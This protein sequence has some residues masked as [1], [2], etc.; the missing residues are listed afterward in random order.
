MVKF[1]LDI[2]RELASLPPGSRIVFRRGFADIVDAVAFKVF[3]QS[4]SPA[5]LERII[6]NPG[7]NDF[8]GD[9]MDLKN[10]T[11]KNKT[12]DTLINTKTKQ[13]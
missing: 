8:R 1:S 6:R 10:R 3:L 4:L 5:S 12:E 13:L 2:R 7:M 9:F 11:D